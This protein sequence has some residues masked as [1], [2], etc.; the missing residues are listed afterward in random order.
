MTSTQRPPGL[1][2]S[3]FTLLFGCVASIV[4]YVL[5]A[6]PLIFVCAPHCY[7]LRA[8]AAWGFYGL[9]RHVYDFY[10]GVLAAPRVPSFRF[11]VVLCT[12]YFPLP[13][14]LDL[15]W[16]VSI[17]WSCLLFLPHSWPDAAR[18]T[19]ANGSV[20]AI[21]I[22]TFFVRMIMHHISEGREED[23][24]L[25]GSNVRPSDEVDDKYRRMIVEKR[26]A[27]RATAPQNPAAGGQ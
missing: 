13:A 16:I 7:A 1:V 10:L 14:I 3:S 20:A 15:L 21:A 25:R 23:A 4:S 2:L 26:R 19:W 12:Y 9:L 6:I 17:F 18:M 27:A 11:F 8:G 22:L 5:A 24:P